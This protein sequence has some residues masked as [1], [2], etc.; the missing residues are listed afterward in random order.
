VHHTN[1]KV[2]SREFDADLAGVGKL[3]QPRAKKL[4]ACD[5][6]S[7]DECRRFDSGDSMP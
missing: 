5:T 2:W 7:D 4:V 6:A 1:T 3:N